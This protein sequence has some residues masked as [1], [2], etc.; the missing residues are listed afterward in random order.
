MTSWFRVWKQAQEKKK[1]R[2]T[3]GG[4]KRENDWSL[5]GESLP[6]C[7][8]RPLEATHIK[9]ADGAPFKRQGS[10]AIPI[11]SSMRAGTQRLSRPTP[12]FS[13]VWLTLL[14]LPSH[15]KNYKIRWILNFD[16]R[17]YTSNHKIMFPNNGDIADCTLAQWVYSTG[18]TGKKET[19]ED[20]KWK[21]KLRLRRTKKE[22]VVARRPA[23]ASANKFR[24]RLDR[25]Q[26]SEGGRTPGFFDVAT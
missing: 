9:V 13:L 4:R 10:T 23:V 17:R 12:A 19:R 14:A 6:C 25:G 1:R 5:R 8:A 11:E 3:E 18:K 22:E 7:I 26:D 2:R 16:S 20:G 21:M 15:S 24:S